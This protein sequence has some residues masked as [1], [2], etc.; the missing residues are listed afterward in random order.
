MYSP[1]LFFVML[2]Y[3]SASVIWIIER[4]YFFIW[5][6]RAYREPIGARLEQ[7]DIR[8]CDLSLRCD[9]RHKA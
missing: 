5:D 6:V 1:G 3:D 2:M 8:R 9:S 4:S 7:I